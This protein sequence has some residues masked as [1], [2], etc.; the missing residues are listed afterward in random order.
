MN[1]EQRQEAI[2]ED[3]R[4]RNRFLYY[5][6]RLSNLFGVRFHS[7]CLMTN[8]YH[9]IVE[10]PEANLSR[11]MQWLNVSYAVY[12]NRRHQLVGHLFQ[13]RFKAI[14]IEADSYLPFQGI[15]RA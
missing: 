8:H 13:G 5:L 9:L 15:E 4:D 14:L 2:F 7:F 1:R 10:T 12:Y 6:E 11:A 3:D